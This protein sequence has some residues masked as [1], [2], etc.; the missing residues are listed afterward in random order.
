MAPCK[1]CGAGTQLYSNGV[2][3]CLACADAL[4]AKPE[5]TPNDVQLKLPHE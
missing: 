4:V 5:L 1:Q 3:I 2:P